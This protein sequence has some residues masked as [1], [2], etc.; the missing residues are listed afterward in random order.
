MSDRPN[1]PDALDIP[2]FL[3][4]EGGDAGLGFDA[5]VVPAVLVR[6]GDSPPIGDWVNV[7][8]AMLPVRDAPAG[9]AA[10]TDPDPVAG[11]GPETATKP[12]ATRFRAGGGRVPTPA[13]DNNP[14]AVGQK[15]RNGMAP[16]RTGRT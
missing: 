3:V 12:P 7:G 2:A 13:A 14:I 16:N 8:V 6:P 10:R 4:A 1:D 9:T 11:N 15:A 5:V